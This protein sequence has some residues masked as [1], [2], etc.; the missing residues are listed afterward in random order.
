M[1]IKARAK[2]S[3]RR[4][5]WRADRGTTTDLRRRFVPLDPLSVDRFRDH[6]RENWSTKDYWDSDVGRRD[7]EEHTFG[8]LVYDRHEYVPW[9]D[10]LRPLDG[11][12]VFEIGCGTGS[13]VM[14]LIEQGAEVTGVDV[15][16]ESIEVSRARLRFFGLRQPPLHHLNATEIG[17]NFEHSS[18]DFVIFFASLEHMTHRERLGSLRAAWQLLADGGILCIIEA[19]NRLWLYDDHTADL[20]F[21]HWLPDEIALEYF[22]QTPKYRASAFD[23]TAEDATL[24]L[25]RRGRGVSYHDIELALGP[26][27]GLEFL[28]DRQ[29]FQMKQ[30]PLRRLYYLQSSNRRYAN[31]LRRQRPDLPFGLF[32]PYL[33]VAIRKAAP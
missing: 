2:A 24:R 31:L 4:I 11:A 30:N 6:L 26:V 29:S 14:A 19:P 18:F 17:A 22:K 32:T 16:P 1:A 27:T 8:R 20:P 7:I 25:T 15:A 3:A 10:A 28:A 33:N 5:I 13:S 23:T 9:L 21:F 12:R